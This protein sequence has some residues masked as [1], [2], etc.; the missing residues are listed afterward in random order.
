MGGPKKL[1]TEAQEDPKMALGLEGAGKFMWEGQR[2]LQATC[3]PCPA[4]FLNRTLTFQGWDSPKRWTGPQISPLIRG[5][6]AHVSN[7]ESQ[8]AKDIMLWQVSG[9]IRYCHGLRKEKQLF[10]SLLH[11]P[12]SQERALSWQHYLEQGNGGQSKD[13]W[14]QVSPRVTGRNEEC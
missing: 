8:L 3:C 4:S 5:K 6:A 14:P 11:H 7:R 13:L 12:E 1:K 9:R 2:T 10:L